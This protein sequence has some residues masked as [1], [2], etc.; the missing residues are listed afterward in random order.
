MGNTSLK[1]PCQN[2]KDHITSTPLDHKANILYF[3]I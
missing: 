2:Y 1:V 3:T